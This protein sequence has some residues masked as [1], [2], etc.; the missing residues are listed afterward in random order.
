[1]DADV[2]ITK[3]IDDRLGRVGIA[4]HIADMLI[5]A[6][7]DHSIVFGLSGSWGSGKTSVL[8]M[9]GELL[10]ETSDPPVVVRFDPWNYPAGSD[11]VTPFLTSLA[12]EI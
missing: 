1:M 9:V 6:P 4:R 3:C 2:P 7:A 12:S 8:N 5:G 10:S 11:L